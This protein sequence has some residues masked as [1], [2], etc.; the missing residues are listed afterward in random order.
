[1]LDEQYQSYEQLCLLLQMELDEDP[2]AP[3]GKG[4]VNE[5]SRHFNFEAENIMDAT[6]AKYNKTINHEL[7]IQLMTMTV[8]PLESDSHSSRKHA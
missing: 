7:S 6:R 8:A 2:G 5:K 3:T 4:R 1:M